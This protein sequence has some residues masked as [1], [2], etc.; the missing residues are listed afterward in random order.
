MISLIICSRNNNILQDLKENIQNTIG[1]KYELIVID[2]SANTYSIFSAYNE[3]VQ[4]AK[5]P[6]LCFMHEDILFHTQNWAEKITN[7]FEDLSIGVIGFAGTHF[8]PSV[9][10]YWFSTPFVTECSL[11]TEKKDFVHTGFPNSRDIVDAVVVDGFCFFVRKSL[12]SEISFDEKTYKGFHLYDMDICMQVLTVGCR[13][14]ICKDIFIQHSWV[15]NPN[16]KG[17]ELFEK[18]LQ[19]FFNKWEASFP[20]S[21]GISDIPPYMLERVNWLFYQAWDSKQVRKSIPYKLG[22]ALLFPL[23]WLKS[24][25]RN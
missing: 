24:K 7:Y 12:F 5:Y 4:R 13:V 21:R 17:M 16:K 9:P 18:N 19:L 23:K 20:I 6:Y 3:G 10:V 15:D 14:C 22:S 8:M 11:R 2:N 25:I 1:V